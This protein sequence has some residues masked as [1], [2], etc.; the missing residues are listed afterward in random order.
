MKTNTVLNFWAIALVAISV[1]MP[2][3][4]MSQETEKIFMAIEFNNVVCGYSEI[5]F[6]DT[7]IQG[8][9]YII[10]DQKTFANF[11]ALGRDISHHQKF[12]YHID[13]ESGSFI[14]H[15]S[16]HNQGEIEM[17]GDSYVEDNQLRIVTLDGKEEIYEI[18]KGTILPNTQLYSY[19]K[20][21]FT[22]KELNSKKYDI[23]D[24]RT[25]EVKE[26][27]YTKDGEE[28]IELAGKEYDAIVLSELD[29]TTG[30]HNKIWINKADGKRLKMDSPNK[31]SMYLTDSSIPKR[32]KTGNW[33]VS[34][35]IKTNVKIHDLR[36]ISYMKAKVKLEAIPQ[37]TM[38]DLNVTGQQFTGSINEN[39]IDGE[40]I[41]SHKKYN[42]K[43]SP[44]FPFDKVKYDIS[45]VY[46][47][48]EDNIESDDRELIALAQKIT[49]GS[50][51]LW[52]ASCRISRWVADNIEGS[53]LDGSAKDTY[54]QK[55]GL[56]GAQSKLMAAL[57]RAVGIPARVVWGCMYTREM[58]GSFGHHGW[59]EVFMGEAG[60][61]AIDVTT[62]ETDYV[63]SGHI[64][65]G[66]LKTPQTIIN[67]DEIE[68]LDYKLNPDK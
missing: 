43:N 39:F 67:Y 13:P 46:F 44:G 11:H 10:L 28:L 53:I 6:S 51:N 66:I 32:I 30:M 25:G 26:V 48:S 38:V 7:T 68:I 41:I 19:L 15:K 12:L 27:E 64:R 45:E 37:A 14:Y 57:C 33:D 23:Y 9:D 50:N 29:P 16:Y 52:D 3:Q 34:F 60:W 22:D 20:N 55:S 18:P 17:G 62:H 8:K 40:F 54:E 5:E 59:N 4:S 49:K 31:I 58:D 24:L 47:E 56:C 65:L 2:L 21:D 36:A 61:I 42:G 35:F 63:D 1:F